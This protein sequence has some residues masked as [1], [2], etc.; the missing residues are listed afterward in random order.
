M[1]KIIFG[2]FSFLA[3]TTVQAQ[4][5]VES[6]IAKPWKSSGH[7]GL[8]MNQ[9]S[10]SNWQAGGDNSVSGN[11]NVNYDLNYAKEDWTWDNKLFVNYGLTKLK[12]EEHK[13][14]D[15]RLEI[16]SLLGKE[17]KGNWYYS[18][19][20]NFKTQMDSGFDKEGVKNS[21][22]FSPA[23]LQIGP[24]LLWKKSENL[25]VNIAPATSRFIFVDKHFTELHESFGVKQGKSMAYQLGLSIGGYYKLDL[26]ENV[27][28]ENILNLYSN[29]LDK[30]QNVVMD[31]QLNIVMTIN[32]YLSTNFTFQ[33]IYDDLAF[34]GF[35]VREMLGIGVNYKF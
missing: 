24:G 3:F 21:H 9:S 1:R 19:F 17:M 26:M 20:A 6:E 10:F 23:Y 5:E 18:A 11:I 30:P 16:N 33:T 15:D 14:T 8:L 29:Y 31:Y 25:K 35:Q 32:K 28:M 13:K 2:L 34:S 22:F 27:S 4:E 7:I 12:G